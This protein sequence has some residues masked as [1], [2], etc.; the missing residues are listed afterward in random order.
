MFDVVNVLFKHYSAIGQSSKHIEKKIV[1]IE[2][3]SQYFDRRSSEIPELEK[4]KTNDSIANIK[5]NL[6]RIKINL[7]SNF[8]IFYVKRELRSTAWVALRMFDAIPNDHRNL[9]DWYVLGSL[10]CELR[11]KSEDTTSFRMIA[12]ERFCFET[13]VDMLGK[14]QG[15]LSDFEKDLHR[16]SQDLLAVLRKTLPEDYIGFDLSTEAQNFSE[17]IRDILTSCRALQFY[18]GHQNRD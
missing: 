8:G 13:V 4:K 3:I 11:M 6:Q 7:L 2:E 5:E 16:C 10:V 1:E 17:M 15:A 14:K 12:I 18:S 9:N